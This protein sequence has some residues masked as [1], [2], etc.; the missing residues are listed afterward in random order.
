MKAVKWGARALAVLL[1][2][3]FFGHWIGAG[4]LTSVAATVMVFVLIVAGVGSMWVGWEGVRFPN[5]R[6]IPEN[7][8]TWKHNLPDV[9]KRPPTFNPKVTVRTYQLDPK[10]RTYQKP[11]GG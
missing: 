2:L 11:E 6:Y 5:D 8:Y 10:P 7:Y 4:W 9:T 1:A 3:A